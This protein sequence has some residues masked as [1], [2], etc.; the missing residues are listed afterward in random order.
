MVYVGALDLRHRNEVVRQQVSVVTAD[1]SHLRQ[2]LIA[3]E[4]EFFAEVLQL[5][6][7]LRQHEA[8]R[9]LFVLEELLL[10]ADKIV[11][12]TLEAPP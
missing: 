11:L 7:I 6:R 2:A 8:E 5:L 10:A 4:E 3:V 9:L 1:T 12:R